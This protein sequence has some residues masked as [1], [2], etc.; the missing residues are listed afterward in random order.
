MTSS[1]VYTAREILY[2][3]TDRTEETLIDGSDGREAALTAHW[4]DG[5]QKLFYSLDEVRQH[6]A[7]HPVAQLDDDEAPAASS[8]R[9]EFRQDGPTFRNGGAGDEVARILQYL[10]DAITGDD[11]QRYQCPMDESLSIP[12]YDADGEQIGVC[13]VDAPPEM[14]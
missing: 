5:G 7:T 11:Y 14:E 8:I 6:V 13:D 10:S 1:E 9:I 3:R 4:L 12:I 2:G